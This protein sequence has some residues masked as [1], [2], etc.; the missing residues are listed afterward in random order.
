MADYTERRVMMVDTQIRPSDVTKFPIIDAMLKVAREEF[1]PDSARDVAYAG[2]PIEIAPGR[3]LPEARN[4]AKLLDALDIRKTELVLHVGAGLGYGT[5]V[6]AHLAEAV[7]GLEEDESLAADAE[8]T[9]GRNGADNAAMVS[10]ALAEGNAKH[11]PYDVILVEGGVVDM[12]QAL[13]DQLKEGG[14]IA[15]VFMSGALGEARIGTKS[16]GRVSWRMD[17]NATAPVLPGFEKAPSFVF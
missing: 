11:G 15:A 4:F 16:S 7:V 17:F 9:L 10:G 3:D 12:P 14:R 5:A 8:A 2:T 6:L 1:V 13:V